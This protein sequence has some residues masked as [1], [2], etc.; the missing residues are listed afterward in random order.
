MDL[1]EREQKILDDSSAYVEAIKGGELYD[2][3]KYEKIVT[4]YGKLLKQ[5]RRVTKLSD[6]TTVNLNTNKMDLQD[7]VYFD[8]LAGIYNR[9]FME[10]R[11]GYIINS[12]GRSDSGIL[13][14]LMI[15]IDFFKKYNDKYGH[16]MGDE[17]IKYVAQAIS[18][19][20]TR[21][22]DFAARYGGEEFVAVLPNTDEK[23]SCAIA[24]K[25][26]ENVKALNIPHKKSKAASYVTISIGITTGKVSHQRKGAE[27]IQRAD[28][29]LYMSKQGGR[30][31]Y[32]HL[33]FE[34]E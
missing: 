18:S 27:F 26:H 29:A 17:C 34:E 14:V 4:E 5:L 7:K 31:K 33:H 1:F 12:L 6:K 23:G 28:K 13:S 30:N 20:I 15:D 22:D 32:T 21:T 24:E 2:S 25:M 11:L 19:S 9:R 16:N 8:A 3:S 10:E